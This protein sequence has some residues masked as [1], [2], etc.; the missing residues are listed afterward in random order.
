MKQ[1]VKTLDKTGKYFPYISSAF[2]GLSSEKLR[3]V[4]FDG[5]QI[6]MLIKDPNFQHS[7]NEIELVSWLSFVEVVQSFLGKRKANNYKGIVQ[8]LLDN[9]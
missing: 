1:F 3:A 7:M 8:K 5:P 6:R 4:I 2:L 9:F